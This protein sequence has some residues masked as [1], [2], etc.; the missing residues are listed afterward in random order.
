MGLIYV[1]SKMGNKRVRV[2]GFNPQQAENIINHF[3]S[4]G[5]LAEPYTRQGNWI[6]FHYVKH[7]SALRA[8]Q[9]NGKKI[10]EDHIVGVAWDESADEVEK[11][12]LENPPDLYKRHSNNTFSIFKEPSRPKP[13]QQPTIPNQHPP[14][15]NTLWNKL[16][17]KFMGW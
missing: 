11:T 15:E 16:R 8:I 17:E 1:C 10:G 4:F 2:F 7:E 14:A 6:T 13:E 9:D 5:D 3:T 12:Q